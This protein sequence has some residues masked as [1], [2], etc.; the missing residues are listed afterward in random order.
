MPTA[1]SRSTPP[2]GQIRVLDNTNLDRETTNTYSLTVQVEDGV[3]T[4]ATQTVTVNITDVNDNAPVIGPGQSFAVVRRTAA[5]TTL[6]SAPS[7]SATLDLAT[8]YGNW[9]ITAGNA[10]GVFEIDAASGQIR[11]LDNTN[12]DRED[13]G[14]SYTLTVQVEDG[15]NTSATQTV[16]VTITDVNDNTPVIDPGQSFRRRPR[17]RRTPPP[18]AAWLGERRSISPPSTATG[19]SPPAMLTVCSRSTPPPGRSASSTIPTSTARRRTP[20]PLR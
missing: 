20:T 13:N 6:P 10:D 2:R 3:D 1:C 7:P 17:M 19:P 4:S 5:D 16:T 14:R 9:T 8:L 12:L 11:V 15:V 18:S